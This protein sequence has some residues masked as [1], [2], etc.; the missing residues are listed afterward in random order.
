MNDI[1]RKKQMARFLH[2]CYLD[3]ARDQG[4]YTS[5]ADFAKYLN[6]PNTSL[7]QWMNEVRLPSGR[8]IYKL[9]DKL[10]APIYEILG[11]PLMVPDNEGAKFII[12]HWHELDEEAQ[13]KFVQILKMELEEKSAPSTLKEVNSH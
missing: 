3:Y 1:Q 9:G 12:S 8:N 11:L 5:L 10:G 4:H 2:D 13:E 7:S 6:V